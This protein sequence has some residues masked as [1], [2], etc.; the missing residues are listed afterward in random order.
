VANVEHAF[1]GSF[2]ADTPYQMIAFSGYV[3]PF[4]KVDELLNLHNH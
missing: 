1:E 2:V 3:T 4:R